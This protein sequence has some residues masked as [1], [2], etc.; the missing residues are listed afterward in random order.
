MNESRRLPR[1]IAFIMDGNGRWAAERGLDRLEGHQA[2]VANARRVVETLLTKQIP[3][4]TLFGFSTE[5]WRRPAGEVDGLLEILAQS[6]KSETGALHEKGACIRHLGRL[7]R[8]SPELRKAVTDAVMLTKDN[9]RI[10][11]NLAF[12]YGGRDE[13]VDAA[14]RMIDDDVPA[15]SVDEEQFSRYLYSGD[16]PDVDLLVRTGGELRLSNFL[17]WQVAYS[18]LY[19][20]P[21]FWPDFDGAE[22]EKALDVYQSRERRFGGLSEENTGGAAAC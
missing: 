15:A 20:T 18:E 7:D 16:L 5:N 12:D 2:G 17:L 11:I 4:V 9:R 1:H 8:L 19:F 13:I 14:R 3:Y 21:V 22:M 10:T 6:I